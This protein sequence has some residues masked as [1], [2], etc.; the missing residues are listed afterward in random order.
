M[1][2]DVSEASNRHTFEA[3]WLGFELPEACQQPAWSPD[4]TG[5][6]L[7]RLALI[8]KLNATTP[9]K[10]CTEANTLTLTTPALFLNHTTW[11]G[12]MREAA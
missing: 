8:T 1:I 6:V 12:G 4:M 10:F 9:I 11:P 3:R 5:I 7:E 2:Y